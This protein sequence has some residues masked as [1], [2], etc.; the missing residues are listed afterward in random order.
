MGGRLIQA[1]LS[2]LTFHEHQLLC[3][4]M[5]L[6]P[7]LGTSAKFLYLCI[8]MHEA[9]IMNDL[10]TQQMLSEKNENAHISQNSFNHRKK[11]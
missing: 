8:G 7:F 11:R 9:V 2:S 10:S 5:T 3:L 6:P 1:T 4:G